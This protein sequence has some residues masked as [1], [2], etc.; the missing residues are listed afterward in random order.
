MTPHSALKIQKNKILIPVAVVD[1]D[2]FWKTKTHFRV[3]TSDLHQVSQ[4]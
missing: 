4:D 3:L 2:F 1:G